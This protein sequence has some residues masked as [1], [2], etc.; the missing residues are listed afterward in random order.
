MLKMAIPCIAPDSLSKLRHVSHA[1]DELANRTPLE[2]QPYVGRSAFAHKGGVHVNAINKDS[3]TYEHIDPISVGND[4]RVLVSDLSGKDTIHLKAR[5]LGVELDV[6]GKDAKQILNR[7]KE[8]EN[9][10][11]QFE[12]AEASFKLVIDEMLGR[13]PKY[14][15]L[16]NL[17]VTVASQGKKAREVPLSEGTAVAHIEVEVGGITEKLT[18]RGDG[19]VNAMEKCLRRVVSSIYQGTLNSTRLVDYKVR[20]MSNKEGTASVVRVLMQ[21]SDG[22]QVWDTVGVSENIIV[23]SWQAMVDGIEFKLVKEG[24]ESRLA[25]PKIAVKV[26]VESSDSLRPRSRRSR[27]KKRDNNSNRKQKHEAP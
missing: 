17:Q 7:I 9:E 19:P 8:L 12:A 20:V 14:F 13:R 23:A 27:S 26:E 3:R 2:T 4:R 22:D 21:W 16:R 11:Y 15:S 25:R 10:G 1:V 6:K 24:V 5:E 18:A